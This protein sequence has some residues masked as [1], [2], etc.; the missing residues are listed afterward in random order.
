MQR[1]NDSIKLAVAIAKLFS[2][3]ALLFLLELIVVVTVA[4]LL[5]LLLLLL[6][7]AWVALKTCRN[8][9]KLRARSIKLSL[10]LSVDLVVA[11]SFFQSR[12]FR[13]IQVL[14]LN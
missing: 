5:L 7:N 11:V 2:D 13:Q 6:L 12:N 1:R 3:F 14:F 10:R 9:G 8:S 4:L